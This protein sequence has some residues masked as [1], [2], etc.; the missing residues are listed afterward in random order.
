MLIIYICIEISTSGWHK[1]Q[2]GPVCRVAYKQILNVV[3]MGEW[4][5]LGARRQNYI[6]HNEKAIVVEFKKFCDNI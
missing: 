5:E 2:K 4:S 6:V 3:V 1:C